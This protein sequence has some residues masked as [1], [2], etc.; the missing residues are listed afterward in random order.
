M[1]MSDLG[2]TTSYSDPFY[3]RLDAF[4]QEIRKRWWIVALVIIATVVVVMVVNSRLQ[5]HPEA[6]SAARYLSARAGQDPAASATALAKVMEDAENTPFFRARAAIEVVQ[7][8]LDTGDTAGAKLAAEL[9][10]TQA[11]LAKDAELQL[12][13][14]ISRA[15]AKHQ[16]GDLDGALADYASAEKAAGAKYAVHQLEAVVGGARVYAAQG[17][18]AEAVQAL[19]PLLSRTDAGAERLLEVAKVS[20]WNLKRNIAEAAAPKAAAPVAP[21]AAPAVPVPTVTPPAAPTP[22]APPAK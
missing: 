8:K 18:K 21:A 22:A 5:R 1:T 6:G 14:T 19:E 12:A 3:D 4:S 9:A 16:A 20:Y 10:V 17:K 15:A 13:A 7:L 2:P 11:A